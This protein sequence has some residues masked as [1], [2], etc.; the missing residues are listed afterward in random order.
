MLFPDPWEK[1][2][3]EPVLFLQ[4]QKIIIDSH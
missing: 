3:R 4:I 1:N 2:G